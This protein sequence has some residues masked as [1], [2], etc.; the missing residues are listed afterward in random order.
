[1]KVDA[2][3]VPVGLVELA[4]AVEEHL[5]TKPGRTIVAPGSTVAWDDCCAGQL[6]ARVITV[7][8]LYKGTMNGV[9]CPTG[10]D[11]TLGVGVIRCVATVDD[12]GRAP[13]AQQITRD[14]TAGQRDMREI[15]DVLQSYRPV[16][17][18]AGR[19]G[20]WTPLGP[21]G[22]CAGGEWTYQMRTGADL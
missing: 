3:G 5:S 1:M 4:A 15:A 19:L 2:Q 9:Q 10:Y 6:W 17:A 18:L 11:F 7:V 21:D 12:R 13:S 20:T 14:G 22:G 16:D 8:P